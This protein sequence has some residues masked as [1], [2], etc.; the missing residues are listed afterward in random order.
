MKGKRGRRLWFKEKDEVGRKLAEVWTGYF[1]VRNRQMRTIPA[2]DLE[3]RFFSVFENHPTI[4]FRLPIPKALNKDGE[5]LLT[6]SRLWLLWCHV[7]VHHRQASLDLVMQ[8]LK[9]GKEVAKPGYLLASGA[10]SFQQ[11][12]PSPSLDIDSLSLTYSHLSLDSP[13]SI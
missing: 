13:F 12:L 3:S 1:K 4:S 7:L 9:A 2:T 10:R 6:Q 5:V 11:S 8:V